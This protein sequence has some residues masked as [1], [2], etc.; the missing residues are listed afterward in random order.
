M[1]TPHEQD[2]KKLAVFV[3]FWFIINI[4][5]SIITLCCSILIVGTNQQV[6]N[7]IKTIEDKHKEFVEYVQ[8]SK[9]I[10]DQTVL[11]RKK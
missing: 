7:K 1:L 6:L 2:V 10:T 11:Q 9:T 3:K 4:I 8:K 5:M